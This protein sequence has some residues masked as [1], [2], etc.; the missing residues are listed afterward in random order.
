M[1]SPLSIL[2][3]NLPLLLPLLA[4]SPHHQLLVH[5]NT[6][7]TIFLGPPTV[8]I[9]SSSR[10]ALDALLLDVLTP[11]TSHTAIIRTALNASFP[12]SSPY[13][14]P[15]GIGRGIRSNVSDDD[16]DDD[17]EF[18][19]TSWLILDNLIPGQRYEVRVCWAATVS[20]P[21]PFPSFF[22]S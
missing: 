8:N 16:D 10:P 22:Y 15:H 11:E 17:D 5:A 12:I 6:E 13:L 20:Q 14:A 7:K 18:G 21:S 1:R 3:H 19:T 2:K 9:P 4:S